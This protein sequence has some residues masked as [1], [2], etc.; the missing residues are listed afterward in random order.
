MGKGKPPARKLQTHRRDQRWADLSYKKRALGTA[1]K[2]SPF[3]GS[4]HAKG[5]VLEKVGVEAKQPNS[6][7]R[8]CV[9]VQLIKNGKKVTAFGMYL[10]PNDGCLNFVDENDEVLLAG[11]GRKGKAKGDIPGVRFKVVKVSGVGLSALWK[12]KKEK[13]RS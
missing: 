1:F 11:F 7:I 13:P 9:R 5:I 12:E 8:K 10:L 3:G 2:S 4:S 6:A